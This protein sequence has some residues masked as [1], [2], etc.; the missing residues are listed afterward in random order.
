MEVVHTSVLLG[1]AMVE[2]HFTFDKTLP[3]NDH[4]HAMDKNDLKE[5][6]KRWNFTQ[7]LLG[8]FKLEAL[9]DEEPARKNARRDARVQF[10]LVMNFQLI[11][12]TV[13]GLPFTGSEIVPTKSPLLSFSTLISRKLYSPFS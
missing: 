11:F 2:K 3:G 9:A 8:S 13:L 6:W 1:A 12:A 10:Y 7:E 4:Y 5:F